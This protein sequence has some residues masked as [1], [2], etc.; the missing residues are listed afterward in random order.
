MLIP[1]ILSGGAG[2]RLWPVSREAYPKPFIR[3]ADGKTL[4]RK[5]IDRAA[6]VGTADAFMT[7][8]NREYYFLT[9]EEYEKS[10]RRDRQL[11]LLEPCGRNT[12][13]A[14]AMAAFQAAALYGKDT[15]LLILPA[16]HLIDDHE[17]FASAVQVAQ[18]IARTGAL[19]TF[20]VVPTRPESGYG[21]IECG[22]A[23]GVDGSHRV[24]RFVE[25]PT[26]E[27]AA[28]F[29]SSD[30][31]LWNSGMFCFSADAF[32]KALEQ[33]APELYRTTKA[34]W[35]AT[36]GRDQDKV[37]LNPE[38]FAK[39]DDI[40]ID[41]AVMEKHHNVA[42]VRANFAWND[43]GSWSAVGDLTPPDAKGNRI[44]GEAVTVDTTDCYIQSEGRVVAAI[45]LKN[46]IVIDTPDALLVTDKSRVQDVKQVVSQLKLQ[47][48]ATHQLHRTVHRP[49]GSYTVLEE[50]PH[51]KLKRIVVKPQASLSLQM[52][53]H[54]SEHWVVLNGTAE[55]VN[56][57]KQYTVRANESTFIPA[58][59]KHRLANHGPDELAI[60]EVQTG[61]YVG[62]DDIVRFEDVYGR[63]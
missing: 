61:S 11:F 47:N 7:V 38:Q 44:S 36:E 1:V 4:L 50:G 55:V 46:L 42:V 34:C 28:Q 43:I 40:S 51:Y 19:V 14:V 21:Y 25:K 58:G 30:R 53:H 32:T 49:W 29:V 31:F 62:E 16:D 10:G 45:G 22:E 5:T 26:L 23:T 6:R 33:C 60:I 8:T 63:A 56:G 57:V 24:A 2:S 17:A 9:K 3:L 52:H 27:V 12:A 54:R 18:N 39:L 48:H 37:Q 41:Y 20:G 35:D 15:Q 13:P 59:C